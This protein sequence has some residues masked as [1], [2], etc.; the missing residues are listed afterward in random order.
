[1][2]TRKIFVI[3]IVLIGQLAFAGSSSAQ[4]NSDATRTKQL[5]ADKLAAAHKS[6]DRSQIRMAELMAGL[7]DSDMGRPEES[8]KH[9]NVAF[10]LW[11]AP[12]EKYIS[13]LIAML[14]ILQNSV[15]VARMENPAEGQRLSVL[16][17]RYLKKA[18]AES[19]DVLPAAKATILPK[20]YRYR[21]KIGDKAGAAAL[22]KDFPGM[23]K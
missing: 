21:L 11:K 13:N 9:L 23:A 6:G 17:M 19:P 10:S 8:E 15:E 3:M 12:G 22:L 14:S 2:R 4:G 7:L 18:I 16:Q 1:M 5:M 20:I